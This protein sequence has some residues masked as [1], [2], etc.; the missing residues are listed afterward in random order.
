MWGIRQWEP[1]RE[2]GE[3]ELREAE[4]DKSMLKEVSGAWALDLD[5]ATANAENVI[6][7]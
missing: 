1:R 2:L 5:E 7:F 3:S 4:L 6:Y